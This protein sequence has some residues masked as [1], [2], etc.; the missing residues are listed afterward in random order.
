MLYGIRKDI[1]IKNYSKYWIKN[2]DRL[3]KNITGASVNTSS[4]KLMEKETKGPPEIQ[5][6]LENKAITTCYTLLACV[7]VKIE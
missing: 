4:F 1:Q 3:I 5:A 7:P 2:N 6:A